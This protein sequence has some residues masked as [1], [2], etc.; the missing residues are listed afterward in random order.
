MPSARSSVMKFSS[1]MSWRITDVLSRSRS[2]CQFRLCDKGLL[3]ANP[4]FIHLD[5]HVSGDFAANFFRFAILLPLLNPLR[6]KAPSGGKFGSP[7]L[8]RFVCLRESFGDLSIF[9]IRDLDCDA[10][11]QSASLHSFN[12]C[13][14]LVLDQ[15]NDA[16]NVHTFHSDLSGD[17]R[18]VISAL[19]K[20]SNF[21]E[22]IPI[23]W[24]PSSDVLDE[25][26]QKLIFARCLRDDRRYGRFSQR[27]KRFN[28]PLG[29]DK[30][31]LLSIG[32]RLATADH[33]NGLFQSNFPD[34]GNHHLPPSP[35]TSSW[36]C[37]VY[38]RNRNPFNDLFFHAVPSMR[39]R[40]AISIK[41]FRLLKR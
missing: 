30:I 29:A 5:Q 2:F 13:D 38:L 33:R 20:A 8:P 22:D 27:K 36:I 3:L 1:P 35:A 7:Q 19:A 15:V 17:V 32:I 9:S 10:D 34:V 21:A 6:D 39:T 40:C 37:N 12:E 41:K 14:F 23:G 16:G 4:L 26:H 24:R 28:S 25:A 31:E 18:N 11:R